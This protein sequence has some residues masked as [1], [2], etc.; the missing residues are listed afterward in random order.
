MVGTQ[1]DVYPYF[2]PAA[3]ALFAQDTH[4]NEFSG[5]VEVRE[6]LGG[7]TFYRSEDF[8]NFF[9][10]LAVTAGVPGCTSVVNLGACPYDVTTQG[11]AINELVGPDKVAYIWTYVYDR[12]TW[13]LARKDRNIATYKILFNYNDDILRQKDDG[14]YGAYT[15]LK[16][17]KYMLDSFHAY[18]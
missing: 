4:R 16:P 14:T 11:N 9:K 10:R 6:W 7:W 5:R 1:Y 3:V 17:I 2:I 15:L 8:I 13:V 12:N 18:N